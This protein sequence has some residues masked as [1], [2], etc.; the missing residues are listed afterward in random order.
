MSGRADR[1]RRVSCHV[2]QDCTRLCNFVAPGSSA[3]SLKAIKFASIRSHPS[4]KTTPCNAL[5]K[6]FNFTK[7]FGVIFLLSTRWAACVQP[8]DTAFLWINWL[9]QSLRII[10]KGCCINQIPFISDFWHHLTTDN[11]FTHDSTNQVAGCEDNTPSHIL[12]DVLNHYSGV[13]GFATLD[14]AGSA[15]VAAE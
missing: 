5:C 7:K 4:D 1:F 2:V 15:A 8:K 6:L 3:V 12:A 10:Q 9:I 14:P 13:S 11:L